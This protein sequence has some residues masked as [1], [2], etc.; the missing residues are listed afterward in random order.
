MLHIQVDPSYPNNLT[1]FHW[2]APGLRL[3]NNASGENFSPR[4]NQRNLATA[5][6]PRNPRNIADFKQATGFQII[7]RTLRKLTF[8]QLL[9]SSQVGVFARQFRE[10]LYDLYCNVR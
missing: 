1:N 7:R 4:A 8:D 5:T 10:H 3:V 9:T 2:K 6:Q